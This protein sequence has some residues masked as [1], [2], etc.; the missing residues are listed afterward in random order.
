MH[1]H[2]RQFRR[3]DFSIG[4]QQARSERVRRRKRTVAGN[5]EDRRAGI[6]PHGESANRALCG[7]LTDQRLRQ[8][9]PP[10]QRRQIFQFRTRKR[11]VIDL[12][13]PPICCCAG[14]RR[15]RRE[16]RLV[17]ERRRA[18]QIGDNSDG[19]PLEQALV[20]ERQDFDSL[21]KRNVD[22]A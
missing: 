21:V 11:E 9:A 1:P 15:P 19:R 8:Q 2:L 16:S 13:K 22:S 18:G 20:A 6:F 4:E 10:I 5:V 17:V 14:K 7:S 12:G 3:I